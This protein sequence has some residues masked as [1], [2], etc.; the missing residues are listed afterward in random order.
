MSTTLPARAKALRE[1]LVALDR[2]GANVEETRLLADLRSD[3]EQPA[4]ELSRALEQFALLKGSGIET[5]EP[6]S[7]A[8]ARKRAATLVERFK[9]ER[10]AATLKKGSGWSNLLKEIKAASIEVSSAIE[11]SWKE[12]RQNVFTGEAPSLVKGRIAFTPANNA[13]FRAYEELHRAFRSEFE[14]VPADKAAIERVKYLAARLSETAKAFDFDVP[15]DVK[16]FLEA[17]QTGGAK[18]DLLTD[19]VLEW[20]KENNASDNYRI[21]SRSADGGR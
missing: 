19:A 9:E 10:K 6:S 4:A 15:A 12:Y 13:A 16:R 2:L 18:L 1:R 7:L 20:L 17:I 8:T 11:R 3:L 14:K 21:V 5:P